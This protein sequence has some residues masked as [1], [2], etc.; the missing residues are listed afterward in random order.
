MSKIVDEKMLTKNG[1]QYKIRKI[2]SKGAI[3]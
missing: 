2:I 3:F 1:K